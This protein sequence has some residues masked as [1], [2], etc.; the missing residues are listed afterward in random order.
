MSQ[1]WTDEML[2]ALAD[3]VVS[4]SGI[5]AKSEER[6][7]AANDILAKSE[8]QLAAANNVLA[9]SE[10]RLATTNDA[11]AE[12]RVAWDGSKVDFA[13]T[14]ASLEV[15][16]KIA[17]SNA[18]SN[19]ANSAAIAAARAETEELKKTLGQFIG[20]VGEFVQATNS[21]LT[22]IEDRQ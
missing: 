1:R 6:L 3:T 22:M 12:N 19:E 16:K 9:K 21:R 8:E 15:T 4:S 5:L 7:A 14:M 11:L 10:E 20:I 13:Q 17:E 18:R 2:D